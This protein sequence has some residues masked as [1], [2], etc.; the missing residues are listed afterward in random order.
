MTSLFLR[1]EN[2]QLADALEVLDQHRPLPVLEDE[3]I[4][5]LCREDRFGE[6]SEL[7][8]LWRERARPFHVRPA[9]SG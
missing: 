3:W 8:Q 7:R 2:Q 6:A 5:G 1:G 9:V 4:A